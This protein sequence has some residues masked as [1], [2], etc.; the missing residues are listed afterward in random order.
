[1]LH[2]REALAKKFSQQDQIDEAPVAMIHS[3]MRPLGDSVQLLGN[4]VGEREARHPLRCVELEVGD[5]YRY[6]HQFGFSGL[7]RRDL[8][9]QRLPVASAEFD[10]EG[11]SPA[12]RVPDVLNWALAAKREASV[13]LLERLLEGFEH[14][15][16]VAP[17]DDVDVLGRAGA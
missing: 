17:K 2:R 14:L 8:Q 12:P 4:L 1:M 10:L 9:L 3:A 11:E 7:G 5:A 15:I 6:R 13:R 16:G